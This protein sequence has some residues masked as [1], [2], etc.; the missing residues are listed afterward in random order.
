MVQIPIV[1]GIYASNGPD[2]RTSYP[3][4]MVPV[5][6]T[7]GISTGF[8]RPA[9]GLVELGTGPGNNRGG[10][11]WNGILYRVMGQK[12][13]S[14]SDDNIVTEYGTIPG[15]DMVSM[16]YSFDLLAIAANGQ[17]FYFDGI[18]VAQVTDPDLGGV[19]DVDWIA[20]YF[21]T[22]DGDSLVVTDL[23]DPFA[24]NP[25]KYGSSEI[26]PDPVIAL[27]KIRNELYAINRNTIEVYDVVG[28]TLFPLQTIE[29]AQIPKGAIGTQ[30]VCVFNDEALAFLGSGRNEAPG[31]YLGGNAS[32]LKISTQEI[33][34]I[35]LT[36]T[37][38]E[39]ALTKLE[40]RNDRAHQFLYV[41][42][43]DR[44]LVYD[45]AASEEIGQPV[46]FTLT[47]A[48]SGFS[49]YLARDFVWAYNQWNIGNPAGAEF[50]RTDVDVSTAYGETVRWEFATPIVYNEGRGAIIN[51]I[52]LV[53]LTG[54]VA[55]GANPV[56]WTS[57]SLDGENWSQT[58]ALSVGTIGQT[59]KRLAWFQQG[60]LQ[61]W[62]VQRFQG[63]TDVQVAF[64]RLEVAIEQ[65]AY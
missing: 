13:V 11:N 14:I 28:G 39:L 24:V 55:L 16:T 44:T 6:K 43:P 56:M 63:T 34:M 25:L 21:V 32:A 38:E 54:H 20:G 58:Q 10:I 2:W 8:L 31:V 7:T 19:I 42:L 26:D 52:E 5:P 36:F 47:T 17:L 30:A 48:L 59:N 64:G 45:R 23:N 60:F 22:T 27:Q 12:L 40:Y 53:A 15:T 4:N 33:D 3:V 57:Y 50:G 46:W 61:N 51:Q 1:Y 62:R 37:E 65:L 29:G 41:H 35:L 49:Q 18:T 9:D